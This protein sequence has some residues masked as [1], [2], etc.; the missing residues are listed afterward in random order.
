MAERRRARVVRAVV[1]VLL[2]APAIVWLGVTAVAKL[3][4]AKEVPWS[5]LAGLVGSALFRPVLCVVGGC[6]P[7]LAEGLVIERLGETLLEGTPV[8]LD[9]DERGRVLVAEAGRMNHGTEDDRDHPDWLLD[10]LAARSVEDRLAYQARAIA[11]GRIPDADHFTSHADRLVVLDDA[12]GDGRVDR[13][14]ELARWND[15]ARGLVAGVEAREGEIFVTAIPDVLRLR[16]LDDDGVAEEM[17]TLHTGFGVKTSLIGHDLHG[18]VQGPDG[19]LYFSVGDRGYRVATPEGHVLE[20][21]LGPGRGAVFR[22]WPDGSGLEVFATGLRNPQELAFDDYGNLVTGDNNGDGGDAARIVYVVEGGES[23]WA[24]PYQTLAG[25][26]VRGPWMAERL[27]DLQHETQPAWVLPPIAHVGNGPAGLVHA[28]GLGLPARYADHFLLCDYAYTYGRSGIWSFAVE[29]EGAGLRVVDLHRFAWSM[30]ATD[31]DFGWDGRLVASLFDQFGGSQEL[32]RI[33]HPDSLDDPRVASLATIVAEPMGEKSSERL[34][35]LLHF[36]DQRIRLR[37]Q[38]ELAER[39]ETAGLA[40]LA[41]D[42]EASLVPRLHALWGL[43]RIGDAGIGAITREGIDWALAEDAELRAQ[44]A[45]AIGESGVASLAPALRDWLGDA[46]P[47][48]RFFAAQS[49]GALADRE[50]LEPLVALLRENADRDVFLRHAVV[51]ALYRLGLPDALFVHADDPSRAVR[52]GVLLVLRREGDARIARFLE[53]PDPLLVVEAARAIYDAPIDGAMPALARLA[54]GLGAAHEDDL[55]T[56]HALHRRVIGA[57]VRLRDARGAERLAR[58]AADARQPETLRR[59]ALEAL[60]DFA[61][62]P[63]RDLTMGF[64]RPLPPVEPTLVAGVFEARGRALLDSSLSARAL[65]IMGGYGASPLDERELVARIV[66]VDADPATRLAAARALTAKA[67][68]GSLEDAVGGERAAGTILD[69]S[70]PALRIAARDLLFA[71]DPERGVT[72]LIEAAEGAGDERERQHAW[73]RLGAAGTSGDEAAR[74]AIGRGFVAWEAGG[75][76]PG[77]ALELLEA[78]RAQ[79]DPALAARATAALAPPVAR[80]IEGRAWALAGGDPAAGRLVFD[81]IGDCRRCHAAAT[82]EAGGSGHGG[83]VGPALGGERVRDARFVLE[84]I[85]DPQARIAP[86]FGNVEVL[87]RDGGR[88][89]GR[90]VSRG[91]DGAIELDT[92]AARP[93]AIPAEAI[94]RVGEVQSAMPPIG[95]AL[96]PRALR[97]LVAYVRSLE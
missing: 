45:R 94:D 69:A 41:R 11:D 51:F 76:A 83:G 31:V 19:R 9:V 97:D 10:D 8:A 63:P 77:V 79:P 23:G 57:N 20:P 33:S 28:P 96:E 32:A 7:E 22:M 61:S 68:G 86:G 80:A 67:S 14:R 4:V 50:S 49:L 92:G 18:L 43:A 54:E 37:A 85:V 21:S 15:A 24:M 90:L 34:F 53:D 78:A 35:E 42:R 82:G 66:D 70:V 58:Y 26:Y 40:R 59:L 36:P 27:W 44:L 12:D 6:E 17:T 39:G 52:L 29:P 87:R 81:T 74:A 72:V 3:T 25:D 88:L 55:Q 62:P 16:D 91:E 73:T 30:L 56:A 5:T 46:S 47:R 75:L 1:L 2:L 38:S 93:L 89:A 64:Y 48:V 84:S 60:A 71:L 65:E 13:R 95:L